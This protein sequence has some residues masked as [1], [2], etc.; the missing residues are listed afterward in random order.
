MLNIDFDY[1]ILNV[2]LLFTFI[3][4]GK[5]VDKGF[6]YWKCALACVISF[7]FVQGTRYARGNDYLSYS[8]NFLIESG[9]DENP[10]FITLNHVLKVFGINEYSCFMF[11]AFTF[12]SCSMVFLY[13]FKRYSA[14]IFPLFILGY[15]NFE[16]YMIRQSFSFSFFFLF[17]LSFF[18][19]KPTSF[20]RIR[21]HKKELSFCFLTIVLTLSFHTG[22]VFNLMV[23]VG[24]YYLF[25]KPLPPYVTI[26]V[27][28][29][30]AY[31]L[32]KIFDFSLLDSVLKF[33]SGQNELAAGYAENSDYWFSEEGKASKYARAPFIMLL[34]TFGLLI[35][36]YLGHWTIVNAES[37]KKRVF[38]TFFNVSF[39]GYCILATFREL[40][41]LHRIGWIMTLGWC[42]V[43]SYI[44]YYRTRIIT[45]AK[46]K[47]NKL[48]SY[49]VRSNNPRLK[50]LIFE[51]KG[52]V[53]R[54]ERFY[55]L[56]QLL[57]FGLLWF[58]YD[59]L[60]YLFFPGKMTQ[61]I[62]DT[63]FSFWEFSNLIS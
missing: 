38:T 44:L 22:N 30:S 60:K 9:N 47:I 37:D 31:I 32:P 61:F 46:R 34:E 51:Y 56:Y 53:E 5:L 49:N 40:E 15:M 48:K 19:S 23:F 63:D 55:P 62:W 17:L 43:V 13:F 36:F 16:E 4:C 25:R 52:K 11:Y 24:A 26:P 33:A 12:I 8:H 29:C 58:L 57:Y 54:F 6:N 41:I 18:K 27:F 1:I 28:I 21:N 50:K 7:S 59:Y 10:A 39:I 42:F 3:L 35:Y 2:L 14:Y 20:T 45:V